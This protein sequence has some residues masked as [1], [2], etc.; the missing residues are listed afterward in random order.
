MKYILASKIRSSFIRR[1]IASVAMSLSI[2]IA[3]VGAAVLHGGIL[4]F[5]IQPHIATIDYYYPV[6]VDHRWGVYR[7]NPWLADIEEGVM[8]ISPVDLD[9][10]KKYLSE[11]RRVHIISYGWPR[12][13]CYC[14]F[15]LATSP[16]YLGYSQREGGWLRLRKRSA[17]WTDPPRTPLAVPRVHSVWALLINVTLTAAI[18]GGVFY[19]ATCVVGVCRSI[20]S[21]G[22]GCARCGYGNVGL[23]T[24]SA[25]PE[26]G[27][28]WG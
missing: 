3:W 20:R 27:A 8:P 11:P 22:S 26:C 28:E 9:L 25:C 15:P 1:G 19:S 24:T 14:I 7:Y 4:P 6:V 21:R 23:E 13:W 17:T 2:H 16:T 5:T 12:Q 18:L 10:V